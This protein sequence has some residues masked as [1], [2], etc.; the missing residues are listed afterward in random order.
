MHTRLDKIST[1]KY[2]MQIVLQFAYFKVFKNSIRKVI[3][4]TKKYESN[5]YMKD[6]NW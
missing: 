2:S 1:S 3:T 6:M 5:E 4:N